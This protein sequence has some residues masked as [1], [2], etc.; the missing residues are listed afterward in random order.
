MRSDIPQGL[1]WGQISILTTMECLFNIQGGLGGLVVYFIPS[2]I[3]S[4]LSPVQ[5]LVSVV[6][7]LL[8]AGFTYCSISINGI[9]DPKFTS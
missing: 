3:E 6:L 1:R 9:R 4:W 8:G 5:L 2:L 7:L